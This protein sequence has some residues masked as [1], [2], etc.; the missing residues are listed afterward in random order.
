MEAGDAYQAREFRSKEPEKY[1][2]LIEGLLKD[3]GI[4]FSYSSY[5]H[6]QFFDLG[7]CPKK[8]KNVFF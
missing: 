8:R 2:E 6:W 3:N 4:E 7:N 1:K 5:Q